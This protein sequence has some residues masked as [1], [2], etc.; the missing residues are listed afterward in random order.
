MHEPRTAVGHPLPLVEDHEDPHPVR[1]K[2]SSDV[3][4][5]EDD[6]QDDSRSKPLPST[7][8]RIRAGGPLIRQRS[9]SVG[10]SLSAPTQV[11]YPASQVTPS[12]AATIMGVVDPLNYSHRKVNRVP[13]PLPPTP[14]PERLI[15]MATSSRSS[16]SSRRSKRSQS[17]PLHYNNNLAHGH[18]NDTTT[19]Q[20]QRSEGKLGNDK[21]AP[22]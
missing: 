7:K 8:P 19:L 13:P 18:R 10:S 16:S 3:V 22:G 9:R 20:S 17:I 5:N 1:N 12:D 15:R 11:V 2:P 6:V 21:P 14:P 4:F